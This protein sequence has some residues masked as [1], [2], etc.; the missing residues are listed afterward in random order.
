M[1]KI[2]LIFIHQ[3]KKCE[4]S[5][6]TIILITTDFHQRLEI[7][8]LAS[9]LLFV[10]WV[11]TGN[12]F[13]LSGLNRNYFISITTWIEYL[14]EIFFVVKI[15][16]YTLLKI[17]YRNFYLEYMIFYFKFWRFAYDE[18]F[19]SESPITKVKLFK[20]YN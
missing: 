2:V 12:L 6:F 4:I 3:C 10:I 7:A 19:G 14:K 16:F 20:I 15:I 18:N 13:V 1:N 17:Y 5:Q 11:Q 8:K 9:Y